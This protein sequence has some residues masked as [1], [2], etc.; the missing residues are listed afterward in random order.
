[1]VP[2]CLQFIAFH[3]LT[4]TCLCYECNS[5]LTLVFV[6]SGAIYRS[7]CSVDICSLLKTARHSLYEFLYF[8]RLLCHGHLF[9]ISVNLYA[10]NKLQRMTVFRIPPSLHATGLID[11]FSATFSDISSISWRLVLVVEE[12]R[13]PP[14]MG[15]QLVNFITC[16][17]ESKAPFFCNLQ[18]RARTHAILVIGLYELLGN[19]TTQLIEPTGP[20]HACNRHPKEKSRENWTANYPRPNSTLWWPVDVLLSVVWSVMSVGDCCLI[21][22]HDM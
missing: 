22:N 20:L 18:S 9:H 1:M 7:P 13:E 4:R 3:I 14:A 17:C 21:D 16:G 10:V 8:D 12:A 5:D 15:K 2:S 6:W 19:P 11:W